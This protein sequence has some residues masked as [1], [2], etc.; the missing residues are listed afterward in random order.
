MSTTRTMREQFFA[1]PSGASLEALAE[2]GEQLAVMQ[3]AVN[4]WIGD[5]ARRVEQRSPETY[6]QVWPE[7]IS[8]GLVARCKAVVEAY[9]RET[10]RNIGATWTMHMN[11][12]N[13]PDRIELLRWMV[14]EGLTSDQARKA[15][16]ERRAAV[17]G[18]PR[19]LLAVD[20]SYFVNERWFAGADAETGS[21]VAE[22]IE[23]TAMRLKEN[24]GLT[25]V[26]CCLDSSR[27]Y[28]KDMTRD[29][30]DQYK[31]DRSPKPTGL[32]AQLRIAED[33]LEKKGFACVRVDGW[34]AD[35]CMAS[36]AKQFPGK[37]TLLTPD[38]DC[39]QLLSG[40]CNI[41]LAVEWEKDPTSGDPIAKYDWLDAK[42]HTEAKGVKP[43]RWADFQAIMGDP[44]DKITGAPGI[45]EKGA[46]NLIQE[47]GSLDKALEA[48]KNP[49]E[50]PWEED[51][52]PRGGKRWK[53]KETGEVKNGA[54]RPDDRSSTWESLLK[55][56]ERVDVVRQLVTLKTDLELP[57]STRIS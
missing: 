1:V 7:W 31:G 41:L 10:D 26:A 53:H 52:G 35:D 25:D 36:Y 12:A 42:R 32:I 16:A 24:H 15:V 18:K 11:V 14:D 47:F 21:S 50:S 9:P 4:W 40:T 46:R 45:G 39:R 33:L 8:P 23:R 22:W 54:K 2:Y 30:E 20:V 13:D 38:K 44:G 55:L 56:A 28:R 48:A 43:D 19:W 17:N 37:V 57:N 49:P 29:W 6:H 34:E 51:A 27:S 5:L 3:R